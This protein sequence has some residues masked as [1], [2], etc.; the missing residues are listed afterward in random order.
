MV[1][2][3]AAIPTVII[4]SINEK[5]PFERLVEPPVSGIAP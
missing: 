3:M 2:S 5:P 1:A 4:S